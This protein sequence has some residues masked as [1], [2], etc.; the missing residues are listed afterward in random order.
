MHASAPG[1][2][3]IDLKICGPND[4]RFQP[5]CCLPFFIRSRQ[6][7]GEEEAGLL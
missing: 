4:P 1:N 7:G 6:D 2:I 3:A 5:S